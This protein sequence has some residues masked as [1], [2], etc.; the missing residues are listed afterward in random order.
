MKIQGEFPFE[1]ARRL[2]KRE[3]GLA[4]KAIE[5]KTG[6]PRPARGRPRKPDTE[7]YRATSIRLHPKVIAWARREARRRKVGY[8]TIINEVLLEKAG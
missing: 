2:T 4:R 1:R 3:A 5:D 6:V 7:R 8:Q